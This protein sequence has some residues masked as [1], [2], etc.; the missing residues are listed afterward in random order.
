MNTCNNCKFKY[1]VEADEEE[2]KWGIEKIGYCKKYEEVI[3]KFNIPYSTGCRPAPKL[4]IIE[5]DVI[6]YMCKYFKEAK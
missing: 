6:G 4:Q 2:K 3:R 5:S 1:F